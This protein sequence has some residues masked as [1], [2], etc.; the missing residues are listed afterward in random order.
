MAL[1]QPPSAKLL[2]WLF[3]AAVG[4]VLAFVC[5]AQYA[6]KETVAGYLV[7]SAG[8]AKIFV[9]QRG[10]VKQLH[11]REGEEVEEGQPL[12]TISTEQISS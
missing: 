1:L 8:T 2:T 10:F 7:P 4:L 5:F 9:P 3:A 6:R 11:V 12:L